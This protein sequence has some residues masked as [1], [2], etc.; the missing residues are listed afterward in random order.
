MKGG[1]I[2]FGNLIDS[3]L[4]LKVGVPQGS[5]LSPLFCNIL[6]MEFDA[7]V[8]KNKETFFTISKGYNLIT[9]YKIKNKLDLVLN[10]GIAKQVFLNIKQLSKEYENFLNKGL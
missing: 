5:L 7:F 9:N 10:S 1:F 2:H 3:D 8:K 6:L 4:I